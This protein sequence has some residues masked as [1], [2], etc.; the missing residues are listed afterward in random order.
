MSTVGRSPTSAS[1][2]SRYDRVRPFRTLA[3][4]PSVPP[5]PDP[6]TEQNL[7]LCFQ[8]L[9]ADRPAVAA[10][11]AVPRP[12]RGQSGEPA[13]LRP[14][15]VPARAPAG[16]PD[17]EPP[18]SSPGPAGCLTFRLLDIPDAPRDGSSH[19]VSSPQLCAV[20]HRTRAGADLAAAVL[21]LL[22]KEGRSHFSFLFQSLS[23]S[24]ALPLFF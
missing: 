14:A 16:T 15:P 6:L 24:L 12:E 19:R 17:L 21:G 18:A 4:F 1:G 3:A 9:L 8:E 10:P 13:V 11:A 20:R 7:L 23:P 5:P 2:A 22:T